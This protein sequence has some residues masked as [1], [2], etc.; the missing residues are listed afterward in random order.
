MAEL[1]TSTFKACTGARATELTNVVHYYDVDDKGVAK[2]TGGVKDIAVDFKDEKL[3]K[4]LVDEFAKR[5]T[6]GMMKQGVSG[7][8]KVLASILKS[9]TEAHQSFVNSRLSDKVSKEDIDKEYQ[10]SFLQ[11][12]GMLPNDKILEES[13]SK[14]EKIANA[15]TE[16]PEDAQTALIARM[17]ANPGVREKFIVDNPEL[18]KSLDLIK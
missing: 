1:I 5:Y 4:A 2:S 7:Y 9:Q 8:A 10:G 14:T 13:L 16:Q 6:E 18:A 11:K 12:Y 15:A 17:L 3:C